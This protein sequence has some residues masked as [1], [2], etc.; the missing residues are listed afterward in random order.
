MKS[1]PPS[2]RPLA[3]GPRSAFPPLKATASAPSSRV[4]ARRLEGAG[5]APPRRR[6]RARRGRGR[7]GPWSEV[8][9]AG[10]QV[11][12]CDPEDH[13]GPVAQDRLELA[14]RRALE[15][16][17]L[18]EP[19][20]RELGCPVVRDAMRRMDHD[21]GGQAL[22]TRHPGDRRR[23][24]AGDRGQR[25]EH[26]GGRAARGHVG[27]LVP[28]EGGETGAGGRLQLAHIDVG[29]GGAPHRR[30]DLVRHPRPADDGQRRRGVDDGPDA[31]LVVDRH[32]G[33]RQPRAPPGS[34]RAPGP[35]SG[36][37][38]HPSPRRRQSRR[39]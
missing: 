10:R 27:G 6:A 37:C 19:P 15:A 33:L 20:A 7:S 12:A 5:A 24:A 23:V 11:A 1:T 22:P 35:R 17:D 34:G 36:T 9:R 25:P 13:R 16:T 8:E 3:C 31:E 26:Q 4:N 32:R 28:G 21:L 30:E 39:R 2:S 38:R 18:D 29:A 14:L